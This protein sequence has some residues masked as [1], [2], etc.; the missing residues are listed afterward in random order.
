MNLR[1]SVKVGDLVNHSLYGVG[2]LLDIDEESKVYTHRIFF[3]QLTKT[4]SDDWWYNAAYLTGVI[5]ESR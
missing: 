5:S 2:I 3:S 4:S 1:W